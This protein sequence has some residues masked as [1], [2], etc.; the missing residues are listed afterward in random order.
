M[1]CSQSLA[2]YVGLFFKGERMGGWVSLKKSK[3][4]VETKFFVVGA[5]TKHAWH[6]MSQSAATFH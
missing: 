6:A 5:L 2:D 1:Y 3:V 4:V